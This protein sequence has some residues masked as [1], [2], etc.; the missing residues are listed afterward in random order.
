VDDTTDTGQIRPE[1]LTKYVQSRRSIRAFKD[2]PVEKEKIAGIFK[3]S[4]LLRPA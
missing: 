4:A 3:L 2:L 1:L